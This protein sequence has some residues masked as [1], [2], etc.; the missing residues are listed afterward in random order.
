MSLDLEL[1]GFADK[2]VGRVEYVRRGVA[3]ELFGAIIDDTPWLTGRLRGN[4]QTSIASPLTGALPLRSD[5]A[6]KAE[7]AAAIAQSHDDVPIFFR[8]NLPYAARIEFDGWSHTKAPAGMMRKNVARILRLV[9]KKI[10][11]G[12]L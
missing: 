7:M 6:A 2:A 1:K 5:A 9:N 4:W 12:K 10:Q 3:M 8:N 11:E